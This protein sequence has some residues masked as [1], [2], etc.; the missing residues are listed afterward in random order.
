MLYKFEKLKNYLD[1]RGVPLGQSKSGF[2]IIK[3]INF[4]EIALGL[5]FIKATG[6]LLRRFGH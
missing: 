2:Q 1:Q 3:E 4:K 6:I 5:M